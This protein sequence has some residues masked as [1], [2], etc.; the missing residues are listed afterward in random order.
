MAPLSLVLPVSS[1]M[2]GK[3]QPHIVVVGA[4]FGGLYT[5]LKLKKL[6]AKDEALITIISDRNYFLFTPLLHEVATGSVGH[7]QV[8][9]SLREFIY[10]TPFNFL[11]TKVSKINLAEKIV[12]TKERRITYDYL[13]L[14]TGSTTNYYNTK[15]AA[16]FTFGLK[17]LR[18]SIT[19][20][21]RFATVFEQAV[22]EKDVQKRKQ[23]LTFGVIGGGPTGVELAAE[24]AELFFDTYLKL[25]SSAI[26]PNE[27]S[28]YLLTQN[29]ELL[30][31]FSPSLR[32]SAL[33]TMRG[34]GVDVHFGAMVNEVTKE[35]VVLASGTFIP[36]QTVIWAAGVK[37]QP[38]A[39]EGVFTTDK[40]GRLITTG[41]L[42]LD[43]YPEV[44]VLGDVAAVPDLT[45]IDQPYLPMLA[46]VATQEAEVVAINLKRLLTGRK[47]VDFY[48]HSRGSLVSIGR[49]KGVGEVFGLKISGLLAW[50]LWRTVYLFKFISW[51]KR[52]KIAVDWTL[53]LLS[54]RDV[55][56]A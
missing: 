20:R 47:L 50:Y 41:K 25:M 2:K 55:T 42:N 11:V 52:I 49:W 21:N 19:L 43:H 13:V 31:Q 14:A 16:E 27:V 6:L 8:V 45:K 28:L 54:P 23:L 48:Y 33:E 1:R 30:G 56:K 29:N 26:L 12:Y 3:T 10:R 15:G 32:Q 4:G 18:D 17:D 36:M 7:H 9:E 40:G 22:L 34:R 46:Q 5:V 37:P 38:P 53:D 39:L 44:F 51:E 24:M 35:G